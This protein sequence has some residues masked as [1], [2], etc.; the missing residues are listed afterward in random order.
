MARL[1]RAFYQQDGVALARALLGKVLVHDAKPGVTKGIIVETEAYMGP[2]DRAAHSYRNPRSKR[3]IVQN[4]E[5]G[6]AY[7]FMIYGMHCC[8]N[9]V[10]NVKDCPEA[11]LLRALMPLEGIPIMQQ[12]RG[13]KQHINLTNGPGKLAEAMGIDMACYGLDLCKGPL[14]LE[15]PKTKEGFA[16]AVSKRINIDYA[17]PAKEFPWRFYIKGNPYV[18]KGR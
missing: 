9:V 1:S 14:Y 3:T 8:M 16:I 4:K 7:V 6:Y 15:E 12:R 18:S 11:V 5:G 13:T 10:A 17:G 2:I